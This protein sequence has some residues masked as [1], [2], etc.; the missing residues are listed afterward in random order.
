[1]AMGERD[2]DH[3]PEAERPGAGTD[4][5]QSE[6]GDELGDEACRAMEAMRRVSL[7]LGLMVVAPVAIANRTSFCPLHA[8]LAEID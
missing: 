2:P 1:M 4:E 5:D 6:G 3:A 8:W 7:F